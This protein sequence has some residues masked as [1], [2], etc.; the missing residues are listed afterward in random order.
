MKWKPLSTVC[1]WLSGVIIL[2]T[3]MI[4]ELPLSSDYHAHIALFSLLTGHAPMQAVAPAIRQAL[5]EVQ[6]GLVEVGP[7]Y[8]SI[9][10]PAGVNLS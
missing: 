3:I 7:V 1:D 5:P 8:R 2:G 6:D 4:V 9:F 10:E